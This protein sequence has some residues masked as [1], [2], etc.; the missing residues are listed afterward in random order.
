M[1][2]SLSF[3]VF[4]LYFPFMLFCERYLAVVSDIYRSVLI[5]IVVMFDNATFKA[6]SNFFELPLKRILEWVDVVSFPVVKKII[7]RM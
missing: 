5:S 4:S 3:S 1:R 7:E 6:S 2:Q